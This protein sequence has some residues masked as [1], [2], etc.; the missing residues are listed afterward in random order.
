MSSFPLFGRFKRKATQSSVP[1][2]PLPPVRS[3]SPPSFYASDSTRTSSIQRPTV[4]IS[5]NAFPY[6][7]Q[8]PWPPQ[9][10]NKP[11]KPTPPTQFQASITP[12]VVPPAPPFF[13]A[14]E[15]VTHSN[16][17][18]A[19]VAEP[20]PSVIST[21]PESLIPARPSVNASVSPP[22][23]VPHLIDIPIDSGPAFDDDMFR[24][25]SDPDTSKN[26]SNPK[27]SSQRGMFDR[28]EFSVPDKE[29]KACLPSTFTHTLSSIFIELFV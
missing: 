8:V 29:D 19:P 14:Q 16:A 12:A 21:H 25:K 1:P 11:P 28:P 18:R 17:F 24:R 26:S 9:N 22:T 6:P 10:P 15:P 13:P 27:T 3:N 20:Q 4:K 23:V 7:T 5:E 2:P